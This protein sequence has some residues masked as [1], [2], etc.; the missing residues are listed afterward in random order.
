MV[1][2]DAASRTAAFGHFFSGVGDLLDGGRTEE[3]FLADARRIFDTFVGQGGW[4]RFG[5]EISLALFR[6]QTTLD[7]LS[8]FFQIRALG[9]GAQDLSAPGLR[10]M[11][12]FM[13][14][15]GVAETAQLPDLVRA[16]NSFQEEM[17]IIGERFL[18]Y[19]QRVS[20]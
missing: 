3:A 14:V 9:G 20:A 6:R 13:D 12:E 5:Q 10:A 8:H 11:S 7:E 17:Q 4:E 1:T 2:F 16:V 18:G 19:A 15:L